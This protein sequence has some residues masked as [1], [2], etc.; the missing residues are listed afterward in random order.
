MG[1]ALNRK[2]EKSVHHNYYTKKYKS[3]KARKFAR[4]LLITPPVKNEE[5]AIK[6]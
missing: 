3:D 1:R 2:L 5:L 4:S 6:Q